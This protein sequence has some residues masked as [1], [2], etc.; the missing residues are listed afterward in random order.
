[1]YIVYVLKSIKDGGYYIGCTSD[2]ERRL[3]D[4]NGGKNRSTRNRR[5]F[6]LVYTELYNDRSAAY[7]REKQIKRYKGGKSFKKLLGEVA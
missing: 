6:K 2:M 5:P 3:R 1:M 7:N 4:H